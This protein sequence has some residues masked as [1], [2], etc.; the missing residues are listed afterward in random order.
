[1]LLKSKR[2]LIFLS[3]DLLRFKQYLWGESQILIHDQTAVDISEAAD[4]EVA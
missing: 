4:A 1:M 3:H 2:S